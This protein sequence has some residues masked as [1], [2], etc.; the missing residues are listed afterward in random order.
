MTS[1]DTDYSYA[2]ELARQL[3]RCPSVTPAEGGAL[4]L[5]ERELT[6]MGFACTRLVFGEGEAAIDNLFARLGTATPHIAF[7]GHTDVVPAG[8]LDAWQFDPFGG[9]I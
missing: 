3:I 6:K 9:D 2:V 4:D 5:L 8:D 1:P 7:A